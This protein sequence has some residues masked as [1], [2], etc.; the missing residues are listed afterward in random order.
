VKLEYNESRQFI[1]LF[2]RLETVKVLVY[3]KLVSAANLESIFFPSNSNYFILCRGLKMLT[4]LLQT[5]LAKSE[6][7]ANIQQG[8]S[9]QQ[10]G[11][12]KDLVR[13]KPTQT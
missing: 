6:I 3:V 5:R 9:R 7:F 13:K 1:L 2:W 12:G 11:Q 10:L 4:S 8:L